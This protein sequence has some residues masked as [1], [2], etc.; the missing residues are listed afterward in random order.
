MAIEYSKATRNFLQ[1][2]GSM[3][4]ALTNGVFEIYEGSPPSSPDNAATGTKLCKVT[5]ASGAHTPE[6][7]SYGSVT[8]TGGASGSVDSI[9]V[10][11]I[12]VLGATVPFDTDLTTT[13]SRVADQINS[14]LSSPDYQAS[15]SGTVITIKA[16]PRTGTTPNTYVIAVSSTTIT[17][18]KVDF[19]GGV[20]AVN[21]LTFGVVSD[22]KLSKSGTWSGVN[23]STGTAG[24]FRITGS[25]VDAGASSTTL[26]RIQGTCGTSGADYN[27]VNTLL[28]LGATHTIAEFD[29]TL[30]E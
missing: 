8:L 27:M 29:L 6:V 26:I 16:M 15:A 12:E 2:F 10:N 11:S 21:G 30:Q 7:L 23:L 20:A 3:K 28:A 17:T 14:W 25:V 13:A 4:L 18:S 19:A 1:N 5:L 22:G 9:T 24:Y